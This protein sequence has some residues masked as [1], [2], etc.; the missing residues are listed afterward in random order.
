MTTC[1]NIFSRCQGSRAA[2]VA[3]AATVTVLTSC[4]SS[5]VNPTRS[6]NLTSL[7][8]PQ[9]QTE[10]KTQTQTES[11]I[12]TQTRRATQTQTRTATQP[13]TATPESAQPTEAASSSSSSTPAWVWW[14]IG[15]V[16][17]AAVVTTVVL[18]RR[19]SKKQAWQKRFGAAKGQ[20]AWFARELIP[21]LGRAPTAAQMTGGWRI[22][23]DR[24][25]AIEDQLT[26]LEATA[27]DD[28][29]R[30]RTRTLRDAMRT[31]RTYLAGLDSTVDTVA[32]ANL[33]RS[34]GAELETA[35]ASVDPATQTDSTRAR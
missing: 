11:H 3:L 20:V 13:A 35:L 30:G 25:V 26:T 17:L 1:R 9:T 15:A 32:A 27:V 19:R 24:I 34:A 31:S 16:V 33:L 4:G 21:Q 23:A 2:L 28:V 10:T 29:G 14:L 6:P 7:R 5:G 22:E 12:A 18:L 8:P